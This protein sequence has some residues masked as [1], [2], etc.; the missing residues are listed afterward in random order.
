M[1]DRRTKV[2]KIMEKAF[3]MIVISDRDEM[4]YG[5]SYLQF[6]ERGMTVIDPK[7]VTL[8]LKKKKGGE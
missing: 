2:E 6:N 7:N 8:K 5:D 1:K 3:D 4:L